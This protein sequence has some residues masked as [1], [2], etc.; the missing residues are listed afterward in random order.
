MSIFGKKE[1]F[2]LNS[3]EQKENMIEK[4]ENAGIEY[5]IRENKDDS[6]NGRRS[7]IVTIEAKDKAKI[8]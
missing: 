5:K 7:Y 2:V 8:A 4:M 1:K 6:M 3:E